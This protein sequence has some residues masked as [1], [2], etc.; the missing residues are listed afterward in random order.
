MARPDELLRCHGVRQEL[1]R[2]QRQPD[3]REQP[4]E[5]L[6]PVGGVVLHP[7]QDGVEHGLL[8]GHVQ[9]VVGGQIVDLVLL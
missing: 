4:G 1:R 6:L 5:V 2:E 9:L 8:G 3:R 7:R